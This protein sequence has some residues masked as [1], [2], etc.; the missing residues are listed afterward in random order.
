MVVVRE[1]WESGTKKV[2]F[3][4]HESSHQF[5]REVQISG[6][7]KKFGFLV[8][9]LLACICLCYIDKFPTFF[10]LRKTKELLQPPKNLG[11][12]VQLSDRTLAQHIG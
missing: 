12:R 10:F 2:D 4:T 9:H 5:T 11:L 3:G 8:P 7:K 6:I 1:D